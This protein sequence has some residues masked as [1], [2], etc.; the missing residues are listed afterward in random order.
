MARNPGKRTLLE[1]GLCLAVLLALSLTTQAWGQIVNE[2]G[3]PSAA[4]DAAENVFL[5]ADRHT[6]QKLADA[7]KLL[8]D[9]R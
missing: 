6:L 8:L 4:E 7:K 2:V 9:G 5:P 1:R 3:K